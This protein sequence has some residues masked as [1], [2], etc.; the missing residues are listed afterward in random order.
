MYT[1]TFLMFHRACGGYTTPLLNYF[2]ISHK[3]YNAQHDTVKMRSYYI[4]I[5]NYNRWRFFSSPILY[6]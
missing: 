4:D 2:I 3:N 6:F 1:Q 5:C